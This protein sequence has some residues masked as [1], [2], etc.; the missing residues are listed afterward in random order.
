M[1][2]PWL[3]SLFLWQYDECNDVVLVVVSV[4]FHLDDIRSLIRTLSNYSVDD[5][6]DNTAMDE[7]DDLY[8]RLAVVA[9]AAA[10]VVRYYTIRTMAIEILNTS[11]VV[12][13][14]YLWA[15]DVW[16]KNWMPSEQSTFFLRIPYRY[17]SV[18]N[19]YHMTIV[20]FIAIARRFFVQISFW[21]SK[22]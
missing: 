5:D 22:I 6:V 3:Y 15:D 10:A 8:N 12:A 9:A 16:S 14:N 2:W 7:H 18:V 13:T 21:K 19:V 20:Y 1:I 17:Y 4:P 11:I